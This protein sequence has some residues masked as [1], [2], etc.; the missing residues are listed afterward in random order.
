VIK[1]SVGFSFARCRAIHNVVQPIAIDMFKQN[2]SETSQ[3]NEHMRSM[4][5][6]KQRVNGLDK[7]HLS[8]LLTSRE[9]TRVLI[10]LTTIDG[11]D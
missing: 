3:L 6:L 8:C 7:D 9:S 11:R 2:K 1:L 5:N 4:L 10:R